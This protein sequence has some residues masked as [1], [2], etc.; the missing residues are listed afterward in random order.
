MIIFAFQ[1]SSSFGTDPVNRLGTPDQPPESK[2]TDK[3][4]MKKIIGDE[5][6]FDPDQPVLK[7]PPG[8]GSR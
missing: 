2:K 8:E 7:I 1:L 6:A 5:K 4:M 3:F